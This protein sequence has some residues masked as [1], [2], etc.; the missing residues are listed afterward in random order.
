MDSKVLRKTIGAVTLPI[1]ELAGPTPEGYELLKSHQITLPSKS[2]VTNIAKQVTLNPFGNKP[3]TFVV[4]R[5]ADVKA[6]P[7]GDASLGMVMVSALPLSDH[8]VHD[9]PYTAAIKQQVAAEYD[10]VCAGDL[11]IIWHALHLHL[12]REARR[13]LAPG[14]LLLQVWPHECD[15]EAARQFGLRL[16]FEQQHIDH[17]V[18]FQKPFSL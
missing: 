6:L 12:Y 8:D 5:V 14:G 7:F 10:A 9:G 18:L 13:V 4:D 16:I 2:I 17:S 11:N 1:V 3:Q 15:A